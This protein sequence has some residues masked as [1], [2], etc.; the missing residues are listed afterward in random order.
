MSIES[1]LTIVVAAA[2]L[3][4]A[5]LLRLIVLGGL[6][7]LFALSGR[8][9]FWTPSAVKKRASGHRGPPIRRPARRAA[10][11][12]GAGL[13]YVFATLGIWMRSA[14]AALG[15]RAGS[16][17]RELAPRL[18]PNRSELRR[19]LAAT[20]GK[21]ASVT[22]VAVASIQHLWRLVAARVKERVD[23]RSARRA[24]QEATFHDRVIVLD[25][26]WDPLTDP[27]E[28]EPASQAR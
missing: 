15:A 22:V 10:R 1:I 17:Y 5:A 8:E 18:R 26:G 20:G 21:V 13:M 27:L 28:D 23:Q 7:L 2:I 9:V 14:G 6:R 25:R 12:L 19:R 3:V 4:G 11:S 16:S 24:R